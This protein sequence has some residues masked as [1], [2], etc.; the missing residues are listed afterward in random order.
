MIRQVRR[1]RDRGFDRVDGTAVDEN[2]RAIDMAALFGVLLDSTEGQE[3][4]LE[5]YQ[6]FNRDSGLGGSEAQTMVSRVDEGYVWGT[7]DVHRC[8]AFGSN[9]G[10]PLR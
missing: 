6:D 8:S 4:L 10:E 1:T 5:T 7:Q 9:H 2:G 3:V